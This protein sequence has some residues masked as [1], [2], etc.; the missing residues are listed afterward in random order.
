[1]SIHKSLSYSSSKKLSNNYLSG[2]PVMVE[3]RLSE[4]ISN[5]TCQY[6]LINLKNPYS[7]IPYIKFEGDCQETDDVFFIKW[8]C[9]EMRSFIRS[10]NGIII[11]FQ[12]LTISSH[13]HLSISEIFQEYKN[14]RTEFVVIE[15][16]GAKGSLIK[17]LNLTDEEV[18]LDNISAV[19][20]IVN[21]RKE[22]RFKSL[23]YDRNWLSKHFHQLTLCPSKIQ[24]KSFKWEALN[25]SFNG[26]YI[27]F[28]GKY[29]FGSDGITEANFIKL[30]IDELCD[31][32]DPI[33]LVVDLTNLD[34]V[35]G[36]DLDVYPVEF[37]IEDSKR[38]MI[39]IVVSV[40]RFDSFAGILGERHLSTDLNQ[41]FNELKHLLITT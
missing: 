25:N 18:F 11:D 9:N 38:D 37:L 3:Q 2:L 19:N 17:N 15:P 22:P 8:R 14:F 12:S 5:L 35:F 16:R 20:K 21:S 39:R 41:S 33:T 30:R 24:Y 28:S 27:S 7:E 10:E 32:I 40:E 31:Y 6:Y 23:K 29:G 4:T 36:D 1:M 26:A 13:L 34:Y